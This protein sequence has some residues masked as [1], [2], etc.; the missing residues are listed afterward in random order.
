MGGMVIEKEPV[1]VAGGL[2]AG[3]GGAPPPPPPPPAH[4]VSVPPIARTAI[5]S[6]PG[7]RIVAPSWGP[8]PLAHGAGDGK[9]G[10]RPGNHGGCGERSG[11]ARRQPRC[12]MAAR[13]SLLRRIA[14]LAALAPRLVRLARRDYPDGLLE[15]DA[16]PQGPP[17]ADRHRPLHPADHQGDEDGGG[18]QAPAGAG[19]GGAR[20]P[21]CRQA[22]R[23]VHGGGARPPCAGPPPPPPPAPPTRPAPPSAPPTPP[24]APPPT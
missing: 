20:P 19:G 10:G 6:A 4:P 18:C 14:A 8:Q 12:Q 2:H 3:F 17:Q 9:L 13:S 24:P 7:V 22:E 1:G 23:D 16:E 21:L 15:P 11:G 5:A